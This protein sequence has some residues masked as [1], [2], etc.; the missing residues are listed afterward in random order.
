MLVTDTK[1]TQVL[2]MGTC[3][4]DAFYAEAAKATVEVLEY[5]G[6]EVMLRPA[7]V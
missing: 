2:M 7:G 1:P 5:L 4:C 3:L 6:V